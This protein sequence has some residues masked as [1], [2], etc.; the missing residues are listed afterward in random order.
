MR[1]LEAVQ[2]FENDAWFMTVTPDDKSLMDLIDEDIEIKLKNVNGEEA[3]FK[4]KPV[5]ITD[6]F[7]KFQL[8][9]GT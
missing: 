2:T 5:S 6:T 7:V 4:L 9:M 3:S 1:V 8:S